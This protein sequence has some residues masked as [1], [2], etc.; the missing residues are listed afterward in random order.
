[1]RLLNQTRYRQRMPGSPWQNP[2]DFG[3]DI[4]GGARGVDL[5][6][7]A[8]LPPA[9]LERLRQLAE[10]CDGRPA[11]IRCRKSR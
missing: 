9:S 1:M 2:S 4:V 7:R 5:R 10:A 6:V 11:K 3:G 8:H